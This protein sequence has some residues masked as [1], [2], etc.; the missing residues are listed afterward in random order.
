VHSG[1]LFIEVKGPNHPFSGK[2]ITAQVF[3]ISAHM[4][5]LGEEKLSLWEAVKA[6]KLTE[7][8]VMDVGSIWRMIAIPW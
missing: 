6:K 2:Y 5:L 4:V 7:E 8:F 3:A 1:Q